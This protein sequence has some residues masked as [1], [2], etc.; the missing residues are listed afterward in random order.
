MRRCGGLDQSKEDGRTCRAPRWWPRYRKDCSGSCCVTGAGNQGSFL[1]HR[2]QR[3]LL[4]RGQEDRSI[5]GKLPQ[6]YWYAMR[7]EQMEEIRH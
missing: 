5:D 7:H 6:S 1:P 4:C 2:W 3:D